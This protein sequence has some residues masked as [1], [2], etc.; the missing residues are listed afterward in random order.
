MKSVEKLVHIPKVWVHELLNYL[1][2]RW[3]K[4]T[5]PYQNLDSLLKQYRTTER[6][7]MSCYRTRNKPMEQKQLRNL[8]LQ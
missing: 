1:E 2:I 5:F 6:K 3:G 8:L 4:S 7:K